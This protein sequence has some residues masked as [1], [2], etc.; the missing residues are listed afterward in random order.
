MAMQQIGTSFTLVYVLMGF[1]CP[2]NASADRRHVDPP[3]DLQLVVWVPYVSS[4][5][6][7]SRKAESLQKTR[8]VLPSK[9]RRAYAGVIAYCSCL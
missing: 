1:I 3:R 9:Y 7:L 8:Y 6:L 4:P 5:H 2:A